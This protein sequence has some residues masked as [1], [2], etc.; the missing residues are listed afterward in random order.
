[1]GMGGLTYT[2]IYE[3]HGAS[4]DCHL[5]REVLKGLR[6]NDAR[7]STRGVRLLK[8]AEPS[9]QR[10]NTTSHCPRKGWKK[11]G[12][13]VGV[14]GRKGRSNVGRKKVSKKVHKRVGA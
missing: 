13:T 5:A 7:L 3:E 1:M 11:Q 9:V 12:E 2:R 4:K 8:R 6:Q 10:G 14:E